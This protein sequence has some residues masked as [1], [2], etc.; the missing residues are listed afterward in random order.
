MG[1]EIGSGEWNG[2]REEERGAVGET[3][4]KHG[5]SRGTWMEFGVLNGEEEGP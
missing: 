3:W 1:V 4:G 2:Q 5:Y